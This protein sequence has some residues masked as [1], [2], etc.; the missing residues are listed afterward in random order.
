MGKT[1][2]H[3]G[4]RCKSPAGWCWATSENDTLAQR[5]LSPWWGRAP[6]FAPSR[7]QR[8][9]PQMEP[10]RAHG[11]GHRRPLHTEPGLGCPLLT[12]CSRR[13]LCQGVGGSSL[14]QRGGPGCTR[15][16]G[17]KPKQTQNLTLA[18]GPWV[19]TAHVGQ[20]ALGPAR[21]TCR[22]TPAPRSFPPSAHTS[23]SRL[24]VPSP[25]PPA[26]A[27]APC[28]SSEHRLP[29]PAAWGGA[30]RTPQT[31]V[32]ATSCSPPKTCLHPHPP[33]PLLK[34]PPSSPSAPPPPPTGSGTSD[35][36][37]SPAGLRPSTP[38]RGL[39]LSI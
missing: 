33:F 8:P 23:F 36:Q 24:S 25:P 20:W 37:V 31:G 38:K 5:P 27:P 16:A 12:G 1:T 17:S 11:A 10:K 15:S 6:S 29:L 21:P 18:S 14:A 39:G 13:R 28:P 4:A 26:P 9:T 3:E 35:P 7:A 2:H 32:P 30:E 22:P 19:T 34:P